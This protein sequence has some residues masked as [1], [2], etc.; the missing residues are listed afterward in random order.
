MGLE[1]ISNIPLCSRAVLCSRNLT[2]ENM[3]VYSRKYSKSLICRPWVTPHNGLIIKMVRNLALPACCNQEFY[4]I[5]TISVDLYKHNRQSF[6]VEIC[7]RLFVWLIHHKKKK[8]LTTSNVCAR[9]NCVT[10]R[11]LPSPFPAF[12]PVNAYMYPEGAEA[13]C[14]NS[15]FMLA[16]SSV[17]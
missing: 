12:N 4:S 14:Y 17:V 8:H 3:F 6:K 13:S 7:M 15:F 9:A 10:H 2:I 11:M 16:C 1:P 5:G